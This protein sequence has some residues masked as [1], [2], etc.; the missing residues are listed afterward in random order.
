[1]TTALREL[2]AR[3]SFDVDFGTLKKADSQIGELEKRVGDFATKAAIAFAATKAFG[4]VEQTIVGV[5]RLN[6]LS[7]QLG[8]STD[9]LQ[10]FQYQAKLTGVEGEEAAQ[11][12]KFFQRAIAQAGDGNAEA[13]QTFAKLGVNVRDANGQI[14]ETPDLLEGVA[15][16]FAAIPSDAQRTELAMKLFGRSGAA[17]IPLLKQGRGGLAQL[18]QEFQKLGGGLKASTI[19]TFAEADDAL[20]R[21]SVT[22]KNLGAEIVAQALPAIR[23]LVDVVQSA[24]T[25]LRELNDRSDVLKHTLEYLTYVA[26][27]AAIIWGLLNIEIIAAIAAFVLIA[28]VVDDFLTTIEGGDSVLGRMIQRL[29]SVAGVN[30]GPLNVQFNTLFHDI[31]AVV[32]ALKSAYQWAAKLLGIKIKRTTMTPEEMAQW[33]ADVAAGKVRTDEQGRTIDDAGT[34]VGVDPSTIRRAQSFEFNTPTPTAAPGTR[35]PI[36]TVIDQSGKQVQVNVDA[37]G[38]TDPT[39][40]GQKTAAAVAAVDDSAADYDA[41]ATGNGFAP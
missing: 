35:S 31:D 38:A 32:D 41:I 16:G 26:I 3:F 2:L 10:L 13:A 12:L 1:M 28:L 8:V 9:D 37:R 23:W 22:S 27:G 7:Q 21:L 29:D 34:G 5:A 6:D 24:A 36:S 25:W 18:R 40:V 11:G 14:G 4:F 33:R 39:A 19:Q 15:D 30:I 20:D 17:L